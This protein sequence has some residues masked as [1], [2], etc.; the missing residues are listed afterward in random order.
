[1]HICITCANDTKKSLIQ[2]YYTYRN[3]MIALYETIKR[4]REN[5]SQAVSSL[6]S[7]IK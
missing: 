7:E 4:L 1:M 6:L 5:L 3:L 2:S